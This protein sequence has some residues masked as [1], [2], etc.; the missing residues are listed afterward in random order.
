[1]FVSAFQSA[2]VTSCENFAGFAAVNGA[3]VAQVGSTAGFDRTRPLRS[4]QFPLPSSSHQKSRPFGERMPPR[5]VLM[6]FWTN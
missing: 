1:V 5:V 2:H 4:Q 6:W 3:G